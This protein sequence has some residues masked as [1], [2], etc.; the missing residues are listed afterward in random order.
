MA[1]FFIRHPVADYNAWRPHYDADSARHEAAGIRRVGVFQNSSDPNDVLVVLES[2]DV[3]ALDAMLADEGLK[4][5]M[6][7]AGVTGPPEVFIAP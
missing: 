1:T 6:Q 7:E 4:A 2:D 3:G 5:K